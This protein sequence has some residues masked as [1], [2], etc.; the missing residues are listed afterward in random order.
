MSNSNNNGMN[1]AAS[2]LAKKGK[3]HPLM[4]EGMVMERHIDKYDIEADMEASAIRRGKGIIPRKI[5]QQRSGFG[6]PQ[7]HPNADERNM[8][9]ADDYVRP[10]VK[11]A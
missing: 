2:Q 6:R 3:N 10:T 11:L 1:V 4:V 7:Y 8:T 5:G 9:Y